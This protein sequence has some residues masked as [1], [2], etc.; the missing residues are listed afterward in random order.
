MGD[1]IDWDL[2][3]EQRSVIELTITVP[4]EYVGLFEN[5]GIEIYDGVLIIRRIIEGDKRKSRI[6]ANDNLVISKTINEILRNIIEIHGQY[7]TYKLF[8]ESYQLEILDRYAKSRVF[9]SDYQMNIIDK[10]ASNEDLIELYKKTYH[11][12]ISLKSELS[13]KEEEKEKYIQELEFLKFQLNEIENAHLNE[14]EEDELLKKLDYLTRIENIKRMKQILI[15]VLYEGENNLYSKITS[16]LRDLENLNDIE[17]FHLIYQK[18]LSILDEIKD[19]RWI[20]SKNLEFEDLESINQIQERLF[21]LNRL[22]KKYSKSIDELIRYKSILKKKIEEM[23]N[24]PYQLEDMRNKVNLL[25]EELVKL[26]NEISKR[27]KIASKKFRN[28]MLKNFSD[29][30]LEDADFLIELEKTPLGPNGFENVNFLFSSSKQFQPKPLKKIASGGE[31]SRI[32]LSIKLIIAG[33]ESPSTLIFDEIDM[34]IGGKTA[35]KV[36]EK[37]KKLSQ[38]YQIVVIT[39]L[40]QIASEADKHFS[41][42]KQGDATIIKEVVDDERVKEIARMLSGVVSD[43]SMSYA[44]KLLNSFKISK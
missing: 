12:Y 4:S 43:E 28:E 9:E 39:H 20:V 33:K 10:Y 36:G 3:H 2:F 6:Y 13:E 29:M 35:I 21:L 37:L 41:I 26:A 30:G 25:Q 19:M 16:L 1:R 5:Y 14:N 22:K 18:L 17:E 38:F 24:L 27:R 40:P 34:G 42:M 11:T 31:L 15:D 44:K 7:E 32:A 8:E 23:E